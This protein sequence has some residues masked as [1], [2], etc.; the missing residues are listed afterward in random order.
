MKKFKKNKEQEETVYLAERTITIEEL[1]ELL[2]KHMSEFKLLNFVDE[3]PLDHKALTKFL[4]YDEGLTTLEKIDN[5]KLADWLNLFKKY[6][7]V[8]PNKAF[9]SIIKDFLI[10]LY[11]DKLWKE[12]ELTM[13]EDEKI[14]DTA[15]CDY[16]DN[17]EIL[18]NYLKN[19]K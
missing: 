4:L 7:E 1:D 9:E 12:R 18:F 2:K 16:F 10:G 13:E 11:I 5:Y 19:L 8:S 3:L 15:K 14:S 17:F 6:D